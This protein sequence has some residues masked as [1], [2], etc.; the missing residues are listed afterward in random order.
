MLARP[1]MLALAIVALAYPAAAADARKPGRTVPETEVRALSDATYGEI[2]RQAC[3]K[4]HCYTPEEMASGYRR[5]FEEFRL[6]LEDKGYI[7]LVGEAGA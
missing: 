6:Q 3:S 4:G 7:I 1:I 5:H 2:L